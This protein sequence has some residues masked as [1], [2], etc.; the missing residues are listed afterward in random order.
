LFF[1][2]REHEWNFSLNIFFSSLF[3]CVF[4]TGAAFAL[5]DYGVTCGWRVTGGEWLVAGDWWRVGVELKS[6][7]F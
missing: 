2:E 5:R 4:L 6:V 1:I 7:K 3:F